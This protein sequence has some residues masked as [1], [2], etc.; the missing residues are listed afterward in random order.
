MSKVYITRSELADKSYSQLKP[1]IKEAV[2]QLP[3]C[4][5]LIAEVIYKILLKKEG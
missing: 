2:K 3:D 5:Q 1:K 4:T